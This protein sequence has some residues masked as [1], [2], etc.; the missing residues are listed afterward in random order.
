MANSKCVCAVAMG[1]QRNAAMKFAHIYTLAN[2]AS[3]SDNLDIALITGKG[4]Q[5]SWNN[6]KPHRRSQHQ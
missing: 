3:Q 6:I 4:N 1:K 2:G 5:N